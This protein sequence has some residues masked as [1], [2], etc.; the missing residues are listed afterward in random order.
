MIWILYT[1][2]SLWIHNPFF[3]LRTFLICSLVSGDESEKPSVFFRSS[4]IPSFTSFPEANREVL[5]QYDAKGNAYN[6]G[7]HIP[8]GVRGHNPNLT[9]YNFATNKARSLLAEAGYPNGFEMK[10]IPPEAWKLEALVMKR[11]YERIGLK[12]NL[13]VFIYRCLVTAPEHHRLSKNTKI[14]QYVIDI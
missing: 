3:Q 13:E 9:L 4:L 10:L 6:P 12:V 7:E 8:P 11:M 1:S 14:N 5:W 2:N